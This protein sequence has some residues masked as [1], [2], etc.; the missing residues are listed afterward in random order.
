M[1][2][3]R[4]DPHDLHAGGSADHRE[5]RSWFLH[6]ENGEFLRESLRFM[7]NGTII[8]PIVRV[9]FSTKA[10]EAVETRAELTINGQ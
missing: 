3:S 2:D 4:S 5:F 6:I 9:H 1:A 10:A 8:A 7:D